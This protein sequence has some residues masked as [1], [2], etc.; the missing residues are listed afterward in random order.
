M[1]ELREFGARVEAVLRNQHCNFPQTDIA[2]RDVTALARCLDRP[3]G[4][5]REPLRLQRVENQRVRVKND[6]A[7]RPSVR[8]Q[9]L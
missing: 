8:R 9:G 7:R 4:A 2:A 1:Q 3:Q 6:H 5:R